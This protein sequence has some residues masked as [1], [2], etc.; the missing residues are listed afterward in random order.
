[1]VAGKAA[2]AQEGEPAVIERIPRFLNALVCLLVLG[3]IV[4]E[5]SS[6][7]PAPSDRSVGASEVLKDY[8]KVREWRIWTFTNRDSVLGRLSSAVIGVD[9]ERVRYREELR[10]RFA[11]LGLDRTIEVTGLHFTDRQGRYLGDSLMIKQAEAAETLIV[12]QQDARLDGFYTRAGSRIPISTPL[13]QLKV[14]EPFFVSHLENLFATRPL[15]VG[16]RIVDS[17]YQPQSFQMVRVAGDVP[18]FMWQ[19]LWKGKIDSV[20][21]VNLTEPEK[22]QLFFTADKRLVR[23]DFVE[24]RIRVYQDGVGMIADSNPNES[25]RRQLGSEETGPERGPVVA[26]EQ[27]ATQKVE[28]GSM[29]DYFLRTLIYLPIAALIGW[30]LIGRSLF[31]VPALLG[32]VSGAIV[33]AL[34]MQLQ[35][36]L[37][38]ALLQRLFPSGS[39]P[40]AEK[41]LGLASLPVLA[42]VVLQLGGLYATSA[43]LHVSRLAVPLTGWQLGAAVGVGVALG[44]AIMAVG[45][46]TLVVSWPVLTER[47]CLLLLFGGAGVMVGGAIDR[48]VRDLS[49]GLG[50][51]VFGHLLF[52][53]LP[54]TVQVDLLDVSFVQTL[55]L[56]VAVVVFLVA[57]ILSRQLFSA[58]GRSGRVRPS[59]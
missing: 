15:K 25:A 54:V 19:E 21:I 41:L 8:R 48:S 47:I 14:W 28:S 45:T 7:Q 50:M 39:T 51:A 6:A 52:R 29:G 23:A 4:A 17:V 56:V 35:A 18:Y 1:M 12:M 11:P 49:F 53:W 20:F 43:G 16:D 24:Q 44:E 9:G 59:S 30:V 2:A 42:A 3:T 57:L 55:Y 13:G 34:V 32:V 33:M 58:S 46:S 10:L 38:A 40:G 31:S 22:M 5:S 36:P 27:Q 37:Q 26:P